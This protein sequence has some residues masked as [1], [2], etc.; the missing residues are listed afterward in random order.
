MISSPKAVLQIVLFGAVGGWLGGVC[1]NASGGLIVAAQ[2]AAPLKSALVGVLAFLTLAL[3]WGWSMKQPRWWFLGGA[4]GVTA[5]ILAV[6]FYFLLWPYEGHGR[7]GVWKTV[8][9]IVGSYPIPVFG[10]GGLMGVFT[11]SWIRPTQDGEHL[12]VDWVLP[13]VI[14]GGLLSIVGTVNPLIDDEPQVELTVEEKEC[15]ALAYRAFVK[16]VGV[17]YAIFEAEKYCE[18]QCD[19]VSECLDVCTEEKVACQAN[20]TK[21]KDDHR[22]C[23]LACPK[24]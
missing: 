10:I 17:S 11:S 15:C 4:F 14:F 19:L 12:W 13:F 2:T 7:A 24:D 5:S 23:V 9:M 20:D 18:V 6:L 1:I 3:P 21:C 22:E 8:L 16:K